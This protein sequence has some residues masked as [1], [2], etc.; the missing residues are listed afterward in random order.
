MGTKGVSLVLIHIVFTEHDLCTV[1][2]NWT[3]NTTDQN[4][5]MQDTGDAVGVVTV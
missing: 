5:G 1:L 3:G 4:E 2:S